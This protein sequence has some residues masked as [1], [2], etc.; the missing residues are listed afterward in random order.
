MEDIE[1]TIDVINQVQFDNAFNFIYSIRTGTP[2]ANMEQVPEEI[3]KP[4]FDKVL[5][6]VQDNARMRARIYQGQIMDA[7]VEEINEN[8]PT[9]VTGRLSNNMIVHFPGTSDLI[10]T[11][12]PVK[13]DECRGFYYMG[14][15]V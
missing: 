15:R 8:D 12:V 14:S 9:L 11:I 5:K 4:G 2:A 6:A 1:E 7:L 13:L 3:V 10:G